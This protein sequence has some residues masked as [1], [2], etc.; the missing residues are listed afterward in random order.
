M[1][2][3]LLTDHG[4]ELDISNFERH[5]P[6]KSISD[7]P[8][9]RQDG[10]GYP[11]QA[12]WSGSHNFDDSF[13]ILRKNFFKLI[14]DT[15]MDQVLLRAFNERQSE[16]PFSMEQLQPF[17]QFIDEFLMAQGLQPDWSVPA[18][19]KLCLHILQQLCGCMHDPDVSLFPY[20]INGVPLG[21]DEDILSV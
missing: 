7:P 16:P 11:S 8:F 10:A 13:Q 21:I 1:I 9:A 15:R 12:D 5:L 17:K 19:Q 18:D 20:L 2:L 14:M 4:I 3:P 6:I